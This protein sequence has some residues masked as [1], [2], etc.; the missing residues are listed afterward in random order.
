MAAVMARPEV[1]WITL[2]EFTQ[3]ELTKHIFRE[4]D[5]GKKSKNYKMNSQ[6]CLPNQDARI[7]PLFFAQHLGSLCSC[8]PS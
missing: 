1:C 5:P 8:S 6:E 4:T 3:G 7:F 2:K